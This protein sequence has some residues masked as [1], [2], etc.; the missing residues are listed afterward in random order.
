MQVTKQFLIVNSNTSST[1]SGLLGKAT[2]F[3]FGHDVSSQTLHRHNKSCSCGET[4]LHE[5]NSETHVRHNL[6]CFFGGHQYTKTGIRNGHAEFVCEDCGH[7][8]LFKINDEK[9]GSFD[10]FHKS[11]SYGCIFRGHRLHLVAERQ[12]LFEYACNCGHS[13]LLDEANRQ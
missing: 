10:E 6:R 5:G 7:P 8:L 9:Y 1:A 12:R 2:C 4:V 11:V 13:F 3:L